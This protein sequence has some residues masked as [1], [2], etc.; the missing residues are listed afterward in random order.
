[1]GQFLLLTYFVATCLK[2]GEESKKFPYSNFFYF[3]SYTISNNS[4]NIFATQNKN[5]GMPKPSHYI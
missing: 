1:M 4:F 3:I 2:R 5:C